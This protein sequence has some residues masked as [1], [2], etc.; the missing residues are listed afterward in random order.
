GHSNRSLWHWGL[1]WGFVGVLP[2]LVPSTGW[3]AYYYCIGALGVWLS[4]AVWAAARPRWATAV[5]ACLTVLRGVM[6]STISYDWGSEAYLIRA[7][8]ILSI[9]RA[10]LL[11]QHPTLPPNTRV[12]IARVPNNIGLI[13]GP[14]SALRVW[15]GDHTVNARFYNHYR[16]RAGSEPGGE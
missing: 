3:H 7:G 9:I 16:P 1:W 8:N 14:T 11:R 10:D 15:Y 2:M 4:F 12:Y 13:A 6:A 5:V